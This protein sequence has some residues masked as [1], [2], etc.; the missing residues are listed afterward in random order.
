MRKPWPI[1]V[2]TG[3]VLAF[4]IFVGMLSF[5]SRRPLGSVSIVFAGLSNDSSGTRIARFVVTNLSSSPIGVGHGPPQIK[6]AAGWQA[7]DPPTFGAPSEVA[8]MRTYAFTSPVPNSE[9]ALWRV[10]IQYGTSDGR[11]RLPGW[12]FGWAVTLSRDFARDLFR[13]QSPPAYCWFTNTPEVSN[14]E[15]RH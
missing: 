2:F 14:A 1:I 6:T 13:L 8:P 4:F 9:E 15:L 3:V 10:P 5:K 7:A 12:Q 11:R